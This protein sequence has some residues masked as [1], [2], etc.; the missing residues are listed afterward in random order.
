MWGIK[1]EYK[2]HYTMDGVGYEKVV[3]AKNAVKAG[4]LL[5]EE[6]MQHYPV[7][8]CD[9][10]SVQSVAEEKAEKKKKKKEE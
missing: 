9:V 8:V 6:I 7:S 3:S 5:K 1:M 10:I 2:V 4:E